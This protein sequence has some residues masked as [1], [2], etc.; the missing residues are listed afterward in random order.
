MY[1]RFE[2]LFCILIE[3][4]FEKRGHLLVSQPVI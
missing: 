3:A 4:S 2:A 1:C